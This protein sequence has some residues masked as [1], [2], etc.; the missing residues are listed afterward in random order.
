MNCF[1]SF[2]TFFFLLSAFLICNIANTKIFVYL[3]PLF[4]ELYFVLVDILTCEGNWY[5]FKIPITAAE[6]GGNGLTLV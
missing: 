5:I 2:Y 1:L 3:P 6:G 4:Y